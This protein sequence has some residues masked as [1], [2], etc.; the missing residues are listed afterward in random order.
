MPRPKTNFLGLTDLAILRFLAD[1]TDAHDGLQPSIREIAAGM[2]L[3][4]TATFAR[5]QHIVSL[6]YL[7]HPDHTPRAFLLNSR[8]KNLLLT[9]ALERPK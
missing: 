2:K 7:T 5:L 8:S 3:S 4:S 6:G 9:N 1:Y